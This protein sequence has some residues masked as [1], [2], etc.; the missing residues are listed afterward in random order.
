M[1]RIEKLDEK[2]SALQKPL[3]VSLDAFELGS[4]DVIVLC[5]GFEDRAIAS[6]EK[7]TL[8]RNSTIVLVHYLP[9]ILRNRNSEDKIRSLAF[10]K[11]LQIKLVCYD[12][13]NPAGSAEEIIAML[14]NSKNVFLDISGMSKLLIVQLIVE[15]KRSGFG[16]KNVTILYSQAE[17]YAPLEEDFRSEQEEEE[18]AEL[19]SFQGLSVISFG[20][21]EVTVVPELSSASMSGYP[22]RLVLFPSFN[23]HQLISLRSELLPSSMSVIHGISDRDTLKWR[24]DA[25]KSINKIDDI[26]L[27]E[28]FQASNFDYRETIA[29]LLRIY[30]EHDKFEKIIIAPTG[31]KMQ[32]VA[33]GI[34]RAFIYDTQIVYPT[35]FKFLKPETYTTG[36]RANYKLDMSDFQSM[37]EED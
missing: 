5:A 37:I 7:V 33:V 24:H 25:L 17:S 4:G 14:E 21:N 15:I 31:S 8:T 23:P 22:I 34:F 9:E 27:K 12:R 36:V 1:L 2:L 19:E 10:E 26:L 11:G 18:K 29:I 35:P 20:V 30:K 32:S 28:E 13:E 16:Y 6:L 3:I